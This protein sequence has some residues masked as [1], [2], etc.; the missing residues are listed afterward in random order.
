[1]DKNTYRFITA[2]L[3]EEQKDQLQAYLIMEGTLKYNVKSNNWEIK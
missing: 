2:L 3:D 1:M